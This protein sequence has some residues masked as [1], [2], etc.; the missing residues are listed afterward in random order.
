[1]LYV[2]GET[3]YRLRHEEGLGM[4]DVKMLAMIGAFIGWKLSIVTLAMASIAG[5]IIGLLTDR[6]ETRWIE[7]RTSVR[8]VPRA[9]CSRRGR[10]RGTFT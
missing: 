7:I 8:H 2:I 6:H 1:V 5:S 3:Y 9:R 4:G 10:C